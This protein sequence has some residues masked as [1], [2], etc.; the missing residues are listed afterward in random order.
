MGKYVIIFRFDMSSYVGKDILISSEGLTQE[1][2]DTA[3]TAEA[4][5]PINLTQTNK[6]F[7]KSLHCNGIH[8]FLFVKATKIY[9]FKA[10]NSE[11][12]DCALCLGNISK[13]YTNNNMKNTG[14]KG[15][16]NFFC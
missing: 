3:L 14:L 4:I 7:L 1:L 9:Q 6:R 10:K 5:Y 2:N 16:G 8:S 11:I 13:D 12:K 15:I